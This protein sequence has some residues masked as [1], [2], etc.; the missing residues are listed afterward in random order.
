[1][2][3]GLGYYYV[4][5]KYTLEPSPDNTRA[6]VRFDV[7]EGEQVIVSDIA[8]RGLEVTRESVV[9]RRIA[10]QVGQPYRPSDVRKTQE[11]IATLGVFSSVTVS[12][13]DP[14]VPQGSKTVIVEVVE[15]PT[16]Y[17]EVRPGLPPGRAYARL[18]TRTVI[19]WATPGA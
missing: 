17:V 1:L 8:F 12:L 10:L 6:R 5:V 14:Y 7:T 18:S 16:Q 2:V 19:S 15:R 3:Q 13:S 4:D 9:R 11:R